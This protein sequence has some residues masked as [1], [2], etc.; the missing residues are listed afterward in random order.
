MEVKYFTVKDC[1][2]QLDGKTVFVRVDTN[3][4]LIK[5][6]IQLNERV[7]GAARTIRKIADR[8]ARVIVGT[9]NGRMGDVSFVTLGQLKDQLRSSVVGKIKYIGNTY[10]IKRDTLN[11]EAI[12]EIESLSN[13]EALLLENLRLLDG[14]TKSLTPEEHA[15]TPFV[16]TLIDACGVQYFFN[17]AFST[18]HRSHRSIVGF[19]ELPNIAGLTMDSEL[20]NVNAILDHLYDHQNGRLN[21]YVLGGVKIQDY[22]DL[23]ENSLIEGKVHKILTGG[24]FANLCLFAAGR[25]LGRESMK[26]LKKTDS[27]GKSIWDYF[28][29]AK[30]LL[31][32]Y[33]KAFELPSDF[34]VD[35]N[36]KRVEYKIDRFTPEMGKNRAILD[37]GHDTTKRYAEIIH[38]AQMVFLKGPLGLFESK[39]FNY[40]SREIL[41][42]VTSAEEA[43]SVM[44]GGDTSVMLNEFRVNRDEIDY[45]SLAG[46]ALLDFL[47]GKTLPGVETLKRS[48]EKYGGRLPG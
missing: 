9:H 26:K 33:P 29:R 44:G 7:K 15:Q 48:Y 35:E 28:E 43:Y 17:D 40:G 31:S 20:S 10:D 37:I 4:T 36:G 24:I 11:D 1:P 5:G 30:K 19:A 27:K 32:D 39:N 2:D 16:R 22:F 14:E 38:R 12:R 18:S 3:T 13:G 41:N 34:A 47:A 46:G 6:Q 45:I 23:V 42:T 8:G 25:D 21:V